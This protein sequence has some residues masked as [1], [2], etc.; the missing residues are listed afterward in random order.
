[1]IRGILHNSAF[2]IVD[3]VMLRE[4]FRFHVNSIV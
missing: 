1:V 3:T 4:R 2:S